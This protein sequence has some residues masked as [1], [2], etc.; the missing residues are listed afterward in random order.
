MALII[1]PEC[2]KEFSS[3]AEK[4]PK[5]GL[6][7]DDA[8]QIIYDKTPKYEVYQPTGSVAYSDDDEEE[9]LSFAER[10]IT[11]KNVII[12][13]IIV[14]VLCISYWHI[15]NKEEASSV[16]TELVIAKNWRF[17]GYVMR[18]GERQPIKV[19]FYQDGEEFRNC[20]FQDLERQEI[21]DMEVAKDGDSFCFEGMNDGKKYLIEISRTANGTS[22]MG[23]LQRGSKTMD[24]T[25]FEENGI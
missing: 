5:C 17:G 21:V 8:L 4:C 20:K 3:Y 9:D 12:A 16:D 14:A 25:L 6:P 11:L 1:C 7:T 13:V 2:G 22:W 24:V 18:N 10:Y 19:S 23:T 15:S